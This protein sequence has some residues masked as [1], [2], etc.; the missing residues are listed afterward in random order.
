MSDRTKQAVS[1]FKQGCS[2][3]QAVLA[4][5]ADRF[6]LDGRTALKLASGFGGG[7]RMG[8]VCGAITGA[9]MVLGLAYGPD[10][11]SDRQ[12]KERTYGLVRDFAETFKSRNGSIMCRELL[13]FDLSTPAGQELAKNRGSFDRCPELVREAVVVLE[14][15]F[16]RENMP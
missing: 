6:G 2:C 16:D 4:A 13:G 3:S 1:L 9:F 10:K 8:E 7:M 5:Y 11:P 14:K 15:I 12:A